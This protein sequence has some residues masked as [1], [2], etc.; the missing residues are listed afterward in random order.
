LALQALLKEPEDSLV[1]ISPAAGFFESVIFHWVQ[2][3]FEVG[4][5]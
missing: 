1:L 2:H 5:A 4:L 3:D